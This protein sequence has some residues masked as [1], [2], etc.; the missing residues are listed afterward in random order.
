MCKPECY[1]G[2]IT[3]SHSIFH[4]VR[5]VYLKLLAFEITKELSKSFFFHGRSEKG[6]MPEVVAYVQKQLV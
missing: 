2:S 6:V 5:S 1:T 3:V 4:T